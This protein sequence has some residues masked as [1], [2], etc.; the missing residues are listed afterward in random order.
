MIELN[1]EQIKAIASLIQREYQA[2][3]KIK[4]A[5][6]K[7]QLAESP[8]IEELFDKIKAIK[9]ERDRIYREAEK[10]TRSAERLLKDA[11]LNN[12]SMV[13]YSKDDFINSYIAYK[14]DELAP[15]KLNESRLKD[16]IIIQTIQ[17]PDVDKLIEEIKK[18]LI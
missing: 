16:E 15:C 17:C 3:Y 4:V 9:I 18:K 7:A 13:N 11:G 5:K 10:L 1:K 6:V 8:E 12:T 2:Q 14:C